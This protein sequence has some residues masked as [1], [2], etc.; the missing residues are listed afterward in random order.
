MT[1]TECVSATLS[2]THLNDGVHRTRLLAEAA[3]DAFGHVDVVASRPS[4]A[5]SSSLCFYG[6]GLN[7]RHTNTNTHRTYHQYVSLL[8]EAGFCCCEAPEH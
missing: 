2:D 1:Q 5:V 8:Y 6:D 4:A 7:T 3:V